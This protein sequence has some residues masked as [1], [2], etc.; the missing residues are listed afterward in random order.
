MGQKLAASRNL[1]SMMENEDPAQNR[2]P[3]RAVRLLFDQLW[4]KTFGPDDSQESPTE[5]AFYNIPTES[6]LPAT[7]REDAITGGRGRLKALRIA[8][9]FTDLGKFARSVGYSPLIYDQI[10]D[11]PS[12]MSRKMAVK[13]AEKLGCSVEELLDGSE[14]VTSNGTHHGTVG[15]TPEIGLPHGSKARYVPLLSM[16]QCGTMMAY[17]D[18]AYDHSGFIAI[19][20]KDGKAFALTL[21]GDSMSPHI[22]PGDVAIVYPSKQPR[23]GCIVIAKLDDDHGGDVMLKLYQ[24]SGDRVILSSYNPAYPPMDWLKRDFRWIYPVASITRVFS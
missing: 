17:D 22:A 24:Q 3:S 18:S 8:A 14:H 21:A 4:D 20:P 13:V 23:N 7:V 16:A 12:N 9:G 11:G 6:E 10:E 5:S 2:P 15:E 1:V 19:D